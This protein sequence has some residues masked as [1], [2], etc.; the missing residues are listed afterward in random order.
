MLK[1]KLSP[2]SG[3]Q[4]KNIVVGYHART[5]AARTELSS[6]QCCYTGWHEGAV[7][8]VGSN[9]L[10]Y[11]GQYRRKDLSSFAQF[12][13]HCCQSRHYSFTIKKCG[14]PT[15][16]VCKPVRMPVED[17]EKLSFLPD[18]VPG[19]YLPFEDVYG[20]TTT[21]EHRPS[22]RTQNLSEVTAIRCKCTTR[23]KCQHDDA[24]R[25]VWHVALGIQQ[26]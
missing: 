26:V 5:T 23:E 7:W 25:G 3:R 17:F 1:T 13:S 10:K 22:M 19:H 11:G 6:F 21:E 15:C 18:P 24:V 2:C 14:Q 4:C 8:R 16:I 9:R 20:T 12:L